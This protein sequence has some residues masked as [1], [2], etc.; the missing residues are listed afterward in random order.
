[1]DGPE[2]NKEGKRFTF[3]RL[4]LHWVGFTARK[5]KQNFS[6]KN[7]QLQEREFDGGWL[8]LGQVFV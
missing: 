1:M 5:D 7:G 2:S 6:E 3:V 4:L 8:E